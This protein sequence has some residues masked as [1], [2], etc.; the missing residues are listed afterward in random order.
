VLLGAWLFVSPWVL[1]HPAVETATS[2]A[3]ISGAVVMVVAAITAS[4]DRTIQRPPTP[5]G[6]G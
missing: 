2:N 5:L 3:V 6:E 1:N 4:D